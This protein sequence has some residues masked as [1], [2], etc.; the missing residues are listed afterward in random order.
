MGKAYKLREIFEFA[1]NYEPGRWDEIGPSAARPGNQEDAIP[2][3]YVAAV[4][5]S[6]QILQ[7]HEAPVSPQ[8]Y[9][10]TRIYVNGVYLNGASAK[11][12]CVILLACV[13]AT[14]ANGAAGDESFDQL[15]CACCGLLSG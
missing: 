8:V 10:A 3:L 1:L 5:W 6:R 15:A 12:V 4:E 9:I 2:E 7:P 14:S 13:A 11:G